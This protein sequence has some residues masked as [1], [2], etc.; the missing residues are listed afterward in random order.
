M[1]K[2]PRR[3]AH[4]LF[5]VI[6]SG[7]TSAIAAAVAS[8]N[9]VWIGGFWTHWLRSWIVAWIFMLPIVIL[10]APLIRR[11]ADLK[12]RSDVSVHDRSQLVP[13]KAPMSGAD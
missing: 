12:T 8:A 2:P 5:A 13:Q 7:L 10:A 3:H 6:Q 9:L 4:F 11:L 1:W